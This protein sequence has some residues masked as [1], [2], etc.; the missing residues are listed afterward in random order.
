MT[1]VSLTELRRLT[2]WPTVG[3][4]FGVIWL[5][6]IAMVNKFWID[7]FT[8]LGTQALNI[9]VSLLITS[10]MIWALAR[11]IRD[12]RSFSPA[13]GTFAY[14]Y[15]RTSKAVALALLITL[16]SFLFL[17]GFG[18]FI[19]SFTGAMGANDLLERVVLTYVPV[20]IEAIV[21]FYGVYHGFISGKR[22]K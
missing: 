15:L 5:S 2:I 12:Y 6:I 7:G 18:V 13:E 20:I 4:A 10:F 16:V 9:Y 22:G 17:A 11:A 1:D 3:A 8:S 21:I 14:R 19:A